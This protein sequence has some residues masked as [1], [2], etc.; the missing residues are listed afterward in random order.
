M[1][2]ATAARIRL[3]WLLL[4]LGIMAVMLPDLERLPEAPVGVPGLEPRGVSSVCHQV[5]MGGVGGGVGRAACA[6]KQ[7]QNHDQ[8]G[9]MFS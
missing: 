8:L 1:A 7:C 5:G 3:L 6:V 4:L 9:G 2:E